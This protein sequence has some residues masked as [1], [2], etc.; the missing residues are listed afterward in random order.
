MLRIIINNIKYSSNGKGSFPNIQKYYPII[1]SAF[2]P[3]MN[4][5]KN[6][7]KNFNNDNNNKFAFNFDDLLNKNN[8]KKEEPKNLLFTHHNYGYK[9]CCTKTQC[10]RKYCE[11][12]NQ[13]RYCV[14]CDCKNCLNQLPKFSSTNI[15]NI[16]NKN[17]ICTCTKSGCNKNYCECFKNGE[18]CTSLCRCVNCE[19]CDKIKNKNLNL[20]VCLANSV[21]IIHNILVIEDINNKHLNID[22]NLLNKKRKKDNKKS[23]VRK[24]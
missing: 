23:I 7:F 24:E 12:F 16:P 17:V 8:E 19:N 3:F 9:C 20:E 22:N 15:K 1:S 11:C 21:Y 14:D 10:V 18:K 4:I 6:T 5:N 13:G 2:L